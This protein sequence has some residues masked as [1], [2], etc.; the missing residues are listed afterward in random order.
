MFSV[1]LLRSHATVGLVNHN[2]LQLYHANHYVILVSSA[3]N[4]SKDEGMIKF[5]ATV[6]VFQCLSLE[7]NGILGAQLTGLENTNIIKKSGFGRDR[8]VQN[9]NELHFLNDLEGK[10]LKV[11]LMDVVSR[12]PAMTAEGLRWCS[13]QNLKRGT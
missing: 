7:Q 11:T 9:K 1:P 6:L 12:E 5:I 8:V 13:T 3:I 2:H 10:E 4:L